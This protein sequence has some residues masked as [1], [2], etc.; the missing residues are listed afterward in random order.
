[1]FFLNSDLIS[2]TPALGV[3]Y[4]PTTITSTASTPTTAPTTSAAPIGDYHL[5]QFVWAA[6]LL[7]TTAGALV[8]LGDNG[9]QVTM[10]LTRDI[11]VSSRSVLIKFP[12]LEL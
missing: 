3:Y 1:M 4:Q 9:T 7:N 5:E 12:D 2:T 11:N 10:E 6:S 8:V